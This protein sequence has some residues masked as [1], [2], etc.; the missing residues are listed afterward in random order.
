M[1]KNFINYLI[2]AFLERDSYFIINNKE[3]IELF[4]NE[5]G[6]FGTIKKCSNQDCPIKKFCKDRSVTRITITTK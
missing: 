3:K 5:V 4:K 1:V 2:K 6:C